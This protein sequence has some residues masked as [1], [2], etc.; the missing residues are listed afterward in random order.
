MNPWLMWIASA[1][2]VCVIAVLWRFYRADHDFRGTHTHALTL[3]PVR[4]SFEGVG[5]FSV[6]Q[7][8]FEMEQIARQQPE[9]WI[10][11]PASPPRTTAEPENFSSPDA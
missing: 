6:Q 9:T 3:P 2:G 8:L 5:T 4:P 11:K 1:I 10:T 7:Q